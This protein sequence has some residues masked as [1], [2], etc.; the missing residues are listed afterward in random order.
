MEFPMLSSQN[1]KHPKTVILMGL[2]IALAFSAGIRLIHLEKG[3]KQYLNPLL[4]NDTPLMTTLDAYYYLKLT[5]DYLSGS[6]FGG[7]DKKDR[8]LSPGRPPFWPY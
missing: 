8:H 2:I 5:D 3:F 7:Q 1:Q 4:E 6:S